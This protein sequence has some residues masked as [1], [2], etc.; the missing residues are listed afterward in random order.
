[1]A[2]DFI[3]IG[4]VSGTWSDPNN[5]EDETTG[6]DP[7]TLAPGL[8]DSVTFNSSPSLPQ[9]IDGTGA[10]AELTLSG[11]NLVI[12]TLSIGS[13]ASSGALE[14][15]A[16]GTFSVTA[17][18]LASGI[19]DNGTMIDAGILTASGN[20]TGSGEIDLTEDST[21]KLGS[22][23]SAMQATIVGFDTSDT[24]EI[25]A[26]I[27][28]AVD[29]NGTLVLMN[30]TSEVGTLALSGDYTYDTFLVSPA[31]GGA[32]KIT[33]YPAVALA[34][35]AQ[36]TID[37]LESTTVAVD[38]LF[39]DPEFAPGG[40]IG[41]LVINGPGTVE[42]NSS[43]YIKDIKVNPGGTF[44]VNGVI[45][46]T[47]PI[48]V[49]A[50]GEMTGT[51][52]FTGGLI[53]PL[54]DKGS[55]IASGGTLDLAGAVNGS[56]TLGIADHSTLVVGGAIESSLTVAFAPGGGSEALILGTP[57]SEAALIEGFGSSDTISFSG[58][59]TDVAGSFS[60]DTLTVT[61]NSTPIATFDFTDG[62]DDGN[63]TVSQTG[64][65]V[66]IV[67][68]LPCF[69][70]GTRIATLRGDVPVEH[71]VVGDWAVTAAGLARPIVWLGHRHMRG[72]DS[73]ARPDTMPV[74][75]RADAFAPGQPARDLILSPQHAVFV[76]EVLIPIRQLINGMTIIQEPAEQ[77]VW[78]H[79]E[80]D[81][82]DVILAEGLPAESYLD[83]GNR[84]V[85]ENAGVAMLHAD[86]ARPSEAVWAEQGCAKLVESGPV[87]DRVGG[88]LAARALLLGYSAAPFQTVRL[89]AT[90]V[91]RVTLEAGISEVHLLSEPATTPGDRRLLGAAVA[92]F[93]LDGV[94]LGLDDSRVR[95]G[96]YPVEG[97]PEARWRWT[98]G[99]AMLRL[100]PSARRRELA[101][102]VVAVMAA[103]LGW[104]A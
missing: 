77:V 11:E 37:P 58:T 46:T 28:S 25:G 39:A 75:V 101:I 51:G 18:V 22:Q 85:F 32:S 30:G 98:D 72:L 6:A 91:V 82:H 9:T 13:L 1:M 3:W 66:S 60:G 26:T 86:F 80:L 100:E 2:D 24:I 67:T 90:G 20:V 5:W 64:S 99:S 10:A 71:L 55:V 47:Y 44:E 96:F 87:R 56:G 88:R 93:S 57:A 81:R 34:S 70:A 52:T 27:T 45:Q 16:T 15:G 92:G 33:L 36:V 17:G 49:A 7:A 54:L 94:A 69:G 84:N 38:P 83:T 78:W 74:R 61:A 102:E 68:D 14:I 63:T 97:E 12:G 59:Y 76:D 79:V 41:T 65:V 8:N 23:P 50:G 19:I 43:R 48:S 29:S 40:L 104:A 31:G 95:Y 73:S 42:L 103:R 35:G 62:Y 89:D 4:P 21:L 53:V